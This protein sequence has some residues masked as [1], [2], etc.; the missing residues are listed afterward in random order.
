MRRS[1][2]PNSEYQFQLQ[3]C[4]AARKLGWHPVYHFETRGSVPGWP[5]LTLIRERIIYVEL[6]AK[7]GKLSDYQEDM[8]M[9][10]KNAGGECYVFRPQDMD[11]V[12]EVLK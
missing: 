12:I 8:L 2:N 3:V 10:L 4:D 6:K 11:E 7:G 5:D 9:R 1:R